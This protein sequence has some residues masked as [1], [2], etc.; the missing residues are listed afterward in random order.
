[1]K[2]DK[3]G[4]VRTTAKKSF[5]QPVE[6][7]IGSST[8]VINGFFK[9]KGKTLSEKLYRIMEKDIE[10]AVMMRYNDIISNESLAVGNLRR[11]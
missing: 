3:T 8:Y 6:I 10:N 2:K 1:M 4:A 7:T 5:V 9:P 11:A